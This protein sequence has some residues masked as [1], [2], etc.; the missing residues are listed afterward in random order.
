MKN[1]EQK[2]K[3][4]D[5]T[6]AYICIF[7]HR[8]MCL[9]ADFR[10]QNV[11]LSKFETFF[12]ERGWG[13]G[14]KQ[15]NNLRNST[16]PYFRSNSRPIVSYVVFVGR[17]RLVPCVVSTLLSVDCHICMH[18]VILSGFSRAFGSSLI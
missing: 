10:I 11:S 9:V 5:L 1:Y 4:C 15:E 6:F 12:F 17:V 13:G 7:I 18:L 16:D 2:K 3:Q 14:G 8:P